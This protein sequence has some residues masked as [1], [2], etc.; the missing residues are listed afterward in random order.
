VNK[1]A[2]SQGTY[3][4]RG[5]KRKSYKKRGTLLE[6]NVAWLFSTLGFDTKTNVQIKNH[7][8]DVIVRSN[9]KSLA[10]ECKQYEKSH[11]TVRN[12]IYEW[13]TKRQIL[14]VDRV[15]LVLWG[16]N[17]KDE[18][19]KLAERLNISIWDEEDFEKIFNLALERKNAARDYILKE[20]GLNPPDPTHLD[21]ILEKFSEV[22]PNLIKHDTYERFTIF[23]KGWIL[24]GIVIGLLYPTFLSFWIL[25]IPLL[26]LAWTYCYVKRIRWERKVLK[27]VIKKLSK[28]RGGVTTSELAYITKKSEKS[29]KKILEYLRSKGYV[30]VLGDLWVSEN[31]EKP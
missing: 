2:K 29:V 12:L 19:R 26:G 21:P 24:S 8:I 30:K 20:F 23:S 7:E 1:R 13:A 11:L 28:V 9:G 31:I 5:K 25:S 18:D 4:H 15:L 17:V 3:K 10:I 14:G 16:S 6:R 22:V 27:S